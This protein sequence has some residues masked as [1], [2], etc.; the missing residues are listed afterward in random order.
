[1]NIIPPNWI[2]AKQYCLLTGYTMD[3]VRKRR[4]SGEWNESICRVINKKLWV[5]WREADK[6]VEK[7][8]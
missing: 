6:W 7:A 2:T 5:N 4:S 1:M 8:A 3:S